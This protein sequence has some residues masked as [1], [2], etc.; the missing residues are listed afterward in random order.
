MFDFCLA[1]VTNNSRDKPVPGYWRCVP[2]KGAN[3]FNIC[4]GCPSGINAQPFHHNLKINFLKTLIMF[5]SC[6]Y[7]PSP[8]LIVHTAICAPAWPYRVV[9]DLSFDSLH[10]VC[11]LWSRVFSE[12]VGSSW[13]SSPLII[14]Q[15]PSIGDSP[16]RYPAMC[17]SLRGL[18]TSG[19]TSPGPSRH[20]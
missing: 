4:A 11:A 1:S 7:I 16:D 8:P 10:D 5:L 12:Q 18:E 13:L 2:Q 15:R 9:E 6:Q 19:G 17:P 3:G 14:D 20:G